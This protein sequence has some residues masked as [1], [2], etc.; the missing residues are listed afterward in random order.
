MTERY[1]IQTLV[2]GDTGAGKSTF[3]ASFPFPRYVAMFDPKSKATPY[4]KRGRLAAQYASHDLETDVWDI[5]SKKKPEELATRIEFFIDADARQGKG[6]LYAAEKFDT[7]LNQ[8]YQEVREG[9]W[10]T[11]IIDSLSFLDYALRMCSQ[12]KLNPTTK[13][14]NDQHGQVHYGHSAAMLEQLVNSKLAHLDCNV[15]LLGHVKMKEDRIRGSLAWMPEAPGQQARKLPGAFGEV[16]Y[17]YVDKEGDHLL[18]TEK[19]EEYFASS[20]IP[21][22]NPCVPDYNELWVNAAELA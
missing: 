9:K 22:P 21:A 1:P 20:Q 11:V 14:G 6:V 4:R 5:H 8:V 7:R 19:G 12:Y 10:A 13:A 15:V 17:M 3:A 18:Q 2:Y 16:Y